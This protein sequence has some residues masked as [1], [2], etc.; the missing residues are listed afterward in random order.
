MTTQTL[1]QPFE[2][3]PPQPKAITLSEKFDKL[4]E[5]AVERNASADAL[6]VLV[7]SIL[8]VKKEDARCQFEAALGRFRNHVPEVLKTKKVSI[9]NRDGSNTTYWHA[10]LDKAFQIVDEELRKEGL[11]A[12]WRSGEGQ[13]GRTLMTCVFRHPS[14]G[15]VE[16]MATLGGPPDTSGSKTP[17]QQIGSIVSYLQRYSLLAAAGVVPKGMDND[18]ATTEGMPED[19]IV[20]Y[21]IKMQDATD[22]AELQKTF[23]ECFKK[24]AE[25]F[26]DLAA[27]RRLVKVYETKKKDFV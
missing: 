8:R 23:R 11:I 5:I 7:D 2:L 12:S 25:Q 13:N 1:D 10:E 19:A 18:A 17:G 6:A 22:L 27:Q 21:C 16:D 14:S 20:D 4:M 24:S 15:H 26:K 9:P 3:T